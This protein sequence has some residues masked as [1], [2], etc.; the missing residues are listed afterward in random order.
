LP[1][2]TLAVEEWRLWNIS[3]ESLLQNGDFV[4]SESR[5]KTLTSHQGSAFILIAGVNFSFLRVLRRLAP[6]AA[7][8]SRTSGVASLHQ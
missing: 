6:Q 2:D 3:Y 4:Q 7:K 8:F 5:P 1:L